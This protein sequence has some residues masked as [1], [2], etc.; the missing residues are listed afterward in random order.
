MLGTN[1]VEI[2]KEMYALVGE[3]LHHW[4]TMESRLNDA[5]G[6]VLGLDSLQTAIVC[7]NINFFAK[8]H[9]LKTAI[10]HQPLGLEHDAFIKTI[11]DLQNLSRQRNMV[12]HDVFFPNKEREKVKFYAVKAKGRFS[13]PLEE[14]SPETFVEKYA[15]IDKHG[16]MLVA[17][18]KRLVRTTH[19][20]GGL[21][22]GGWPKSATLTLAEILL[23][24]PRL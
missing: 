19:Y 24:A 10:E 5:I 8:C 3:Y 7:S 6:K 9:I 18:T 1:D 4:A 20:A 11:S 13:L 14:W 12:A 17:L 22:G 2:Y 16:E 23:Q 15:I 21:L